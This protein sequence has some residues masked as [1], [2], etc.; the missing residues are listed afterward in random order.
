MKQI[1]VEGVKL[2]EHEMIIAAH[3]VVPKDI[4]VGGQAAAPL[5]KTQESFEAL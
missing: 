3:L 2:A 4:K 1:G 5:D